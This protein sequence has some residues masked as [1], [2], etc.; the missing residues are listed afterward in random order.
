MG[1]QL[2]HTVRRKNQVHTVTPNFNHI[3]FNI[4]LPASHLLLYLP[5]TVHISHFIILQNPMGLHGLLVG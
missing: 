4:I 2:D 1:L 5:C 3:Q